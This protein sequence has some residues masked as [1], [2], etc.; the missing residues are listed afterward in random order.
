MKEKII[1]FNDGT[2]Q[3]ILHPND[4][5]GFEDLKKKYT[6]VKMRTADYAVFYYAFRKGVPGEWVGTHSSQSVDLYSE[7]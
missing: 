5:L 7:L 1:D 3:M 4:I 6:L 2:Q